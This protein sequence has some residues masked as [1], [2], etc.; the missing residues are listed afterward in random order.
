MWE[1]MY[2]TST[3]CFAAVMA[4]H[5]ASVALSAASVALS[6]ALQARFSGAY[7]LSRG[8]DCLVR[9]LSGHLLR[10]HSIPLDLRLYGY[11]LVPF[12]RR[13]LPS[14]M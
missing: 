5:A 12:S 6:A 10:Y 7:G 8:V 13:E 2:A 4:L 14:F 3:V 11:K 1:A 9:G